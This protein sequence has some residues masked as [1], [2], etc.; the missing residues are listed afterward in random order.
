MT[1][2]KYKVDAL[3]L[4]KLDKTILPIIQYLP[5]YLARKE[6]CAT[7]MSV[8]ISY[9]SEGIAVIATDTRITLG[10]N[11]EYGW[12]DGNEKLINVSGMGWCAGAGLHDMI[13]SFELSLGAKDILSPDDIQSVFKSVHRDVCTRLPMFRSSID[14]TAIAFSWLGMLENKI[15]CRCGL[16][17]QKEFGDSIARVEDNHFH[18]LYPVEYVN[19]PEMAHEFEANHTMEYYFDGQLYPLLA[20]TV[21]LFRKIVSSG[22]QSV[23]RVC[24]IGVLAILPDGLYK[25]RISKDMD[26]LT[27]LLNRED[28]IMEFQVE[29]VIEFPS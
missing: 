18:I 12:T 29:R 8:V 21:D 7:N 5:T 10:A 25:L 19:R 17:C 28:A 14:R 2:Y 11:S 9:V 3:D 4:F 22:T 16:M 23:S 1:G 27:V 24:A 15:F 20:K 13:H 6:I 26:E